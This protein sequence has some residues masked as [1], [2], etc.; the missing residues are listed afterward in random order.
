MNRFTFKHVVVEHPANSDVSTMVCPFSKQRRIRTLLD[1]AKNLSRDSVVPFL[2]PISR[3]FARATASPWAARSL[4]ALR[5][6]C[7][8][9]VITL[10][11]NADVGFGFPSEVNSRH[12]SL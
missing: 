8:I 7:A 2:R 11:T 10:S 1:L 9:A 4:M 6:I 5:S 12:P 3:P